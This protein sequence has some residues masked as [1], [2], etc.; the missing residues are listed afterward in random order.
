MQSK[1][2][3]S[4]IS[5]MLVRDPSKRATLGEIVV[6]PWVAAGDRGHAEA[7]PLIVRHHL[8]DDAHDTI[9]EQMVAGGIGSE[10]AV[11]RC[12][13]VHVA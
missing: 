6:Y 7:L 5:R 2:V 11:L 10:E 8:P 1:C 9:V 3:F 12:V 4:L 13:S